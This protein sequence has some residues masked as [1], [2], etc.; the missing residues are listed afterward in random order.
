[1]AKPSVKIGT[2]PTPE[3]V[4]LLIST[5]F[6]TAKLIQVLNLL[7][8]NKIGLIV[9]C[10][11]RLKK[12]FGLDDYYNEIEPR[13]LAL[14]LRQK[15]VILDV[16]TDDFNE[17]DRK[18][19]RYGLVLRK[20]GELQLKELKAAAVKPFPLRLK[21]ITHIQI[22][23]GHDIVPFAVLPNP[24]NWEFMDPPYKDTLYTD[25]VYAD[26]TGDEVIDVPIARIPDGGSLDLL[27]KQLEG[28]CTPKFGAFGLG[29]VKRPYAGPIMDIFDDAGDVYW[30]EPM[31]SDDFSACEVDVEHVYFILHGSK[32]DTS[33][34][35]GE[36]SWPNWPTA[37]TVNLAHSQGIILSGCCYGAY[38]IGKKP[39]NS[40]CLRFL[41]S[42][43]KA[44]VGCTGIHYSTVGTA[45]TYAGP[46]FHRLF[47]EHLI[48]GKTPSEA[49]F[50]AKRDYAPEAD[51]AVEQKILHEFV[52]YGRYEKYR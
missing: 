23:G 47:F 6:T 39:A 8:V 29:N 45:T 44:F 4:K 51:T 31:T 16:C 48:T 17:V 35:S 18:I 14:A 34:W 22:V 10:T 21:L 9:T 12:K 50:R 38:I 32:D 49:F 25:D 5:R 20:I 40:I 46:L 19:K 13:L 7:R 11:T 36:N 43:A 3:K 15:A 28:K 42:G 1:M 37:F 27:I 33:V 30:S 41:R 52:F 26:F 2:W 24:V